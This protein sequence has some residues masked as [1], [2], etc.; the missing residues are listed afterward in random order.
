M[1]SNLLLSRVSEPLSGTRNVNSCAWKDISRCVLRST[2]SAKMDYFFFK[3][4]ILKGKHSGKCLEN[5]RYGGFAGFYFGSNVVF[6]V[7]SI[8]NS[9]IYICTVRKRKDNAIST[10]TRRQSCSF[11]D[12]T[13]DVVNYTDLQGFVVGETRNSPIRSG[14]WN[15]SGHVQEKWVWIRILRKKNWND[16]HLPNSVTFL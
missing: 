16:S 7:F 6:Y 13:I 5:R 15:V 9:Q 14:F 8:R 3:L 4:W 1:W 12:S 10:V 11:Q 2:C